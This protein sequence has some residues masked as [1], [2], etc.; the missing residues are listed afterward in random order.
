MEIIL[1]RQIQIFVDRDEG[2]D[3]TLIS[4]KSFELLTPRRNNQKKL[5][6]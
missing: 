5:H 1:N 3:V 2:I 6:S 4:S